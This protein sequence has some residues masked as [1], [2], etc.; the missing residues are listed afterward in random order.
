MKTMEDLFQKTRE[1]QIW[2][3]QTWRTISPTV[4]IANTNETEWVGGCAD[5]W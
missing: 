3:F 4:C 1:S 5:V 2:G